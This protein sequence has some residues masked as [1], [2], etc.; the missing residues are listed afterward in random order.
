MDQNNVFFQERK[1]EFLIVPIFSFLSYLV[2]GKI[3]GYEH[4]R[5]P[6][7]V[8]IFILIMLI[9]SPNPIFDHLLESS[10]RPF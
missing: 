1:F 8:Q 5:A 3:P 6:D 2:N 10:M 9:S 4:C 7:K